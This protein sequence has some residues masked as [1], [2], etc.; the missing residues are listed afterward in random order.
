MH[1]FF[2]SSVFSDQIEAVAPES[3][4]SDWHRAL[5][6]AVRDPDE[7]IELLGL[8][9]DLREPARR[10]A[11]LFPLLVPRGYLDRIRPGDP[12]DPLL[13]QVLPLGIEEVDI[14]GFENDPVG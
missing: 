3:G 2:T 9:D 4:E 1:F 10:A 12:H 6:E 7:L 8:P 5:S 14:A 13:A 11:K